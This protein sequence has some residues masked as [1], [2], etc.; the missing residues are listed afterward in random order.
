MSLWK[1]AKSGALCK[2]ASKA[3]GLWCEKK[4]GVLCGAGAV[5]DGREGRARGLVKGRARCSIG[6]KHL[7]GWWNF[8]GVF[9]AAPLGAW[10]PAQC[11]VGADECPPRPVNI[12]YII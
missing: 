9:P 1:R 12:K 5:G 3:G 7:D 2:R 10:A 8:I 6:Q 4:E 11:K